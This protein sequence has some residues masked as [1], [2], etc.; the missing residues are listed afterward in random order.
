M[1]LGDAAQA[2]PGATVTALLRKGLLVR[3][4]RAATLPWR[5]QGRVLV[6][7]DPDLVPGATLR[8][9]AGRRLVVD[10]HEDY[11]ALLRDRSW[12]RGATG[13]VA[14]RVVVLADRLAATADLTVVADKH[15]T[16]R[17]ARDRLVVRN[18][19]DP[20]MLPV[21]GG[22]AEPPRAV[23]VGDLRRSRGLFAMLDAVAAAPGWHLDLVGP[24]AAADRPGLDHR[25]STDAELAGRIHLHGRLA[26]EAAWTH[27]TGAWVGFLLLE[28]TPAFEAALPTKLYEY[29][30]CGLAVVTT[31]LPRQ[32]E[33]V[34]AAGAGAV[35]DDWAGAAEALRRWQADP[36][37]LESAR[38][39]ARRWYAE[40]GLAG[41]GYDDLAARVAVLAGRAD[42]RGAHEGM[43]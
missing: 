5:A 43:R 8:R 20:S 25:L 16:P 22:P 28:R 39:G 38:A 12:A 33:L 42:G 7:L 14:R 2:P 40:H 21:A 6:T 34:R 18:L 1:G 3:A 10:V 41:T 36:A 11:A 27:A 15:L 30:A 17:H 37:D 29:L 4:V 13:A 23:Y 19:P 9:V 26:P 31:P 35:V 24:V 32:A